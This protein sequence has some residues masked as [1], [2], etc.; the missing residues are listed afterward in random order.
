MSNKGAYIKFKGNE[1]K[2]HFV[3]FEAVVNKFVLN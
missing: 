1:M 3:Q 2:P